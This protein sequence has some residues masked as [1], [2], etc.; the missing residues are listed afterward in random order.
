[1]LTELSEWHSWNASTPI[2][3]T[4]SGMV[5]ELRELQS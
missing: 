2:E 1:M 3:V 5:T 4:E